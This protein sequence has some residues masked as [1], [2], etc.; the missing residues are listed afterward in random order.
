LSLQTYLKA[1]IKLAESEGEATGNANISSQP[2]NFT[3]RQEPIFLGIGRVCL[4]FHRKLPCQPEHSLQA[5]RRIEWC[6]RKKEIDETMPSRQDTVNDP[7]IETVGEALFAWLER[8]VSPDDCHGWQQS[9][10]ENVRAKVH[11]VMAVEPLWRSSIEPTE[12][13]ELRRNH[14]FERAYQRWVK[15]GLGKAIAPK[16][17]G[18]SLLMLDEPGG[19]VRLR[20]RGSKVQVQASV[21]FLFPGDPRS[22]FGILHEDHCA[23]RRNDSAMNAFQGSLGRLTIPAPIVGVDDK[24]AALRYLSTAGR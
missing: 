12:L 11:V 9:A 4:H 7:T 2:A 19:A 8:K 13:F 5:R 6:Q 21:D 1:R 23:H 14:I 15:Q 18:N 20:E 24:E 22:R 10:Q 17:P 16:T 3:A